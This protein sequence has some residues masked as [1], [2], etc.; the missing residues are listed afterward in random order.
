KIRSLAPLSL[1]EVDASGRMLLNDWYLAHTFVTDRD[2]SV[3]AAFGALVARPDQV[4]SPIEVAFWEVGSLI[5]EMFPTQSIHILNGNFKKIQ[6]SPALAID[7][8]YLTIPNMGKSFSTTKKDDKT[9]I[10]GSEIN[11]LSIE[12]LQ[13]NNAS[14][15]ESAEAG[16]I[17][18]VETGE[19]VR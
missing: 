2:G 5:K 4:S 10:I 9:V 13:T 1:G 6:K 3:S 19:L 11:V 18:T 16:Y 7:L 14:F 17:F 12:L 15:Y 8:V